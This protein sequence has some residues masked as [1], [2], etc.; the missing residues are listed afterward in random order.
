[1]TSNP[2]AAAL[3]FALTS[4]DR[5]PTSDERREPSLGWPYDL[6]TSRT[7]AYKAALAD[8][9]AGA[10]HDRAARRAARLARKGAAR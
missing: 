8:E 5:S 1:M 2:L 10:S 6:E 7:P 4:F 3:N 9:D